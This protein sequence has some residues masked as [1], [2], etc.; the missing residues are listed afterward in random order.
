MSIIQKLSYGSYHHL[1]RIN[2]VDVADVS[3]DGA[4]AARKRELEL[5]H[6]VEAARSEQRACTPPIVQCELLAVHYPTNPLPLRI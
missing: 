2:Y 5:L 1:V 3:A 6:A 4:G